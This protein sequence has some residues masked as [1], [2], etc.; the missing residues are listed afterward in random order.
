MTKRFGEE[1]IL[2]PSVMA[3]TD[4]L[5]LQLF[6]DTLRIGHPGNRCKQKSEGECK[7]RINGRKKA[8][9]ESSS[10]LI[11]GMSIAVGDF[12]KRLKITEMSHAAR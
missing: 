11:P 4:E 5:L 10:R 3:A 9:G 6:V 1:P 2:H 7:Q 8:H 12:Q